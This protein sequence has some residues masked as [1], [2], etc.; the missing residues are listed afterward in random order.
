ML[1]TPNYVN[2]VDPEENKM[3]S[4][5]RFAF[6][7]V[8]RGVSVV[9]DILETVIYGIVVREPTVRVACLAYKNSVMRGF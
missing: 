4:I 8:E 2:Q 5:I 7:I 9:L 1:V 3:F 6:A